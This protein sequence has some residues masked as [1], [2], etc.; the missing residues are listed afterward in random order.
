VFKGSKQID[1]ILL[2]NWLVVSKLTMNFL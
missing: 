2:R 1:R